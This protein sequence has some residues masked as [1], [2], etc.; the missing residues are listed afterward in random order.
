[1]NEQSKKKLISINERGDMK[2]YF[3]LMSL[4][5]FLYH[6]NKNMDNEYVPAEYVVI[7]QEIRANMAKKLSK[8][9]KMR[10]I[11]MTGGLADCVNILGLSFQ[12]QGPLA[13]EQLREIL[14]DCVEEFL[15]IINSNERLRPNLKNYPF[16]PKE[17]EITLFVIGRNEEDIFD[18]FI[19]V[20]YTTGGKLVYNTVDKDDTFSYKSEAEESY[21]EALNIVKSRKKLL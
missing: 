3:L 13:K 15:A 18:P 8:R 4:F 12:I 5:S 19:G 2:I 7:A 1:M 14:I 21:E 16:S 20:A 17:I 10:V 11:G 9:H 6:P